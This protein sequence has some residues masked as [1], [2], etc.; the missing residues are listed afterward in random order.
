MAGLFTFYAMK[1]PL[2]HPTLALCLIFFGAISS[3][4]QK[5]NNPFGS[6][7]SSP[8][9]QTP[10]TRNCYTTVMEDKLQAK[11][12]NRLKESEFEMAL[13]QLIS[14][15]TSG[16]TA[17]D[18]VY[19]IP[20]IV[21]IVHNG[22]A[23]GSGANIS[24]AQIE[25]QFDV[26]NEDF[27]RLG[28]GSNDHP[29]GADAYIEFYP[30]LQD[31]DGNILSE[32]GVNRINGGK[33]FWGESD[34]ENTLKPDSY[35]DPERYFNI[36][37]LTF[38]G[39]LDGVLGYA[40]FPSLSGLTGLAEDG[41]PAET[42]GIVIGHQFFGTTGSAVS[43]F[44]QGR[45]T[46]HE[47]GHWLG[48]RH[49]WGDGGC[50]VD[51]YCSDTPPASEP[52]F[53]CS[54]SDTCPEDELQDMIENYMDYTD[55]A[56][57]N[58]FTQDQKSRMRIVLENSPRRQSL[59]SAQCG[60][61]EVVMAG[62]NTT[63]TQGWYTYTA[64]QASI[65]TLSSVGQTN[66]STLVRVHPD[67]AGSAIITN[68][69][70]FGTN[71]SEVAL[72]LDADQSIYIY[73]TLLGSEGSF[74]WTLTSSDQ[75][76]AG[77]CSLSA[78]ATEGTN[79]LPATDLREYWYSYTQ[80]VADEKITINSTEPYRVYTGSCQQLTRQLAG[81][82]EMVLTNIQQDESI[83]IQFEA[84]GGAFDWTLISEPLAEGEGCTTA[85]TAVEGINNTTMTAHWYTFT[86]PYYGYLTLSSSGQTEA[87]TSVSVYESCD[88]EL[89]SGNADDG[90]GQT[91][92]TLTLQEG[93]EMKILW[94]NLSS[95]ASFIWDLSV[96]EVPAG[97]DCENPAQITAGSGT[98][99]T[100]LELFWSVYT[101]LANG[102]KLLIE[103]EQE[104]D[105][106]VLSDCQVTEIYGEGTQVV[107]ALG[108][109]QGDEVLIA[110]DQSFL[111]QPGTI[112]YTLIE[113]DL[114]SGD[115]CTLP[116][117]A[118]LGVNE[119]SDVPM[120]FSYTPETDGDLSISSV[121]LT[122]TDTYLY[123]FDEC[124]EAPFA[125]NDDFGDDYQSKLLLADMKAGETFYIYWGNEYSSEPF[126]WNLEQITISTG[127]LCENPETAVQGTNEVPV[128]ETGLFWFSYTMES[129]DKKLVISSESNEYVG[130]VPD[131]QVS[132]I[133]SSGLSGTSVVGLTGGETLLILWENQAA[134]AFTFELEEVAIEAGDVC[135]DPLEISTGIQ[136]APSAPIWYHFT[137]ASAG[138]L[139][140]TSESF[141]SEDTYLLV[142][143]ACDGFPIAEID[144][145]GDDYQST[146][147]LEVSAGDELW[148]NWIDTYSNLAFQW[149]LAMEGVPVVESSTITLSGLGNV[150]EEIGQVAASDP[151]GD[152]LYYRITSSD[153]GIFSVD[154]LSGAIL[155]DL[156][157]WP[158]GVDSY[159][160][161][162]EV[163]DL[164]DTVSASVDI[165]LMTVLGEKLSH[166]SIYPNPTKGIL[167]LDFE[168]MERAEFYDMSG[169]MVL[170]VSSREADLSQLKSGVYS[171]R[172]HSAG[173]V[174]T[175]RVVLDR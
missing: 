81:D 5:V 139:V 89:L 64:S 25:S 27:R 65:V 159:S 77:A 19:Y 114:E 2:S 138:S 49:I 53:G 137:A 35:W 45:T 8:V 7:G 109:E 131:C 127:E 78:T 84:D 103:A 160:L 162:V 29:D 26:L 105:I 94:E 168:Q 80:T 93:K 76:A 144:D 85:A 122:T 147:I 33:V 41:G 15:K 175:L 171:V 79:S 135:S 95:D 50:T 165:E 82:G 96:E 75:V 150:I 1:T 170:Q 83:F 40:Q 142:Y 70:A 87:E 37:V 102:Q 174:S 140:I 16:R 42:D 128:S 4:A 119:S 158:S 10:L 58:L 59:T 34:I 163:T 32:P 155:A 69:A 100:D 110:W 66:L 141:T 61:A 101:V 152:Q 133:Y 12:P 44:D 173:G 22:E 130:A 164:L 112:N 31:P 172:I 18:E 71:Q 36:W 51:D 90:N 30:V 154:E 24:L 14:Q 74:D 43:P 129:S 115:L 28:N 166:G 55:D 56:C 120:W 46:T 52:N 161:D 54:D 88:L 132:E 121:G 145:S 167:H 97:L 107:E 92:L 113:Q 62:T 149:G 134:T 153:H 57:M 86:M 99:S 98:I 151:N 63:D 9:I 148:I 117:T 39:D 126:E 60:D 116:Q 68:E 143:D 146:A 73:W 136:E 118:V 156:S 38:G 13:E 72:A 6:I 20:T 17:S 108:M 48:L 23:I 157:M 169:R 125:E 67:C 91:D 123:V 3:Y 111:D 11:Y 106:Y 104:V 124:G 47:V 21:H